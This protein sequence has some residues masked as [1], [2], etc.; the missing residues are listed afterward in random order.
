MTPPL[1][2][3][4]ISPKSTE[5]VN[6][7]AAANT[8][9]GLMTSQTPTVAAPLP[10]SDIPL[11]DKDAEPQ[12][13][14][15]NDPVPRK[16][17]H[18]LTSRQVFPEVPLADVVFLREANGSLLIIDRDA[19]LD[20][21]GE[22]KGRRRVVGPGDVAVDIIETVQGKVIVLNGHS[23]LTFDTAAKATAAGYQV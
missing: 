13:P 14:N 19:L 18:S 4:Q 2:P 23:T 16:K 9:S 5:P 22:V 11:V 20:R 6:D 17:W 7:S 21:F 1:Q 12:Y 15:I 3:A 10:E 8:S